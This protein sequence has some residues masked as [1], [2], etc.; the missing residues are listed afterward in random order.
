M[1][2]DRRRVRDETMSEVQAMQVRA[3]D[4]AEA[5]VLVCGVTTPETE[6]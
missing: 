6:A 5:D 1:F 2:A 3:R 4:V